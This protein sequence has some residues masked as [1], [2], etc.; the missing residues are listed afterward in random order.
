MLMAGHEGIFST[1]SVAM[2]VN[3]AVNELTDDSPEP[4]NAFCIEG[5]AYHLHDGCIYSIF[6]SAALCVKDNG[7][8]TSQWVI[9]VCGTDDEQP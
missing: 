3:S 7:D 9:L 4:Q 5:F 6:P 8:Q 1:A 2:S